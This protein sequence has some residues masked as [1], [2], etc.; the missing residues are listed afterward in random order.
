M[1]AP[2]PIP[3]KPF[4]RPRPYTSF[5]SGA[6]SPTPINPT[7]NPTIPHPTPQSNATFPDRDEDGLAR[8]LAL[9]QSDARNEQKMRDRLLTQ[10]EDDLAR[11]LRESL[12]YT[13]T[14]GSSLAAV[15]TS[16]ARSAPRSAV[17]SSFLLNEDELS[18]LVEPANDDMIAQDEALALR[19]A[20]EEAGTIITP[21][22]SLPLAVHPTSTLPECTPEPTDH[23]ASTSNSPNIPS[24]APVPQLPTYTDAARPQGS[25]K[26]RLSIDDSKATRSSS[27]SPL[28][29][30]S[31][32]PSHPHTGDNEPSHRLSRISSGASLSGSQG[33]IPETNSISNPG[34]SVVNVNQ[35]VDQR[36]LLGVSVGFS[37]PPISTDLIMMLEVMPNIISL[38]YGK[39]PPLH[40]QGPS[41][42]HLLMLMA[43]LSGTRME[44]ATLGAVPVKKKEKKLRTVI[45]FVKPLR[46]SSEWRTILYFTLDYPS[47][48][49]GDTRQDVN[50]L[51]Y[52]YS[53]S[54]I[55]TLL[56]DAADTSISKTYTIPA[57]NSVPYPTLPITF[58]N[59]AMYLHAALEDSRRY[60]N[61]SSRG[62]RKL[63]KMVQTCYPVREEDG[64]PGSPERSSV[65]DLFKRVIGRSNNKSTRTG[66][67]EDTY[68]LV[69][70]FVPNE[71]G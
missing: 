50:A 54:T 65:G 8:A 25:S 1:T 9:S 69:T 39:C 20:L 14:S 4:S 30:Q 31:A 22:P 53:L 44:V 12:M 24:S 13:R 2:P 15:Q 29:P 16:F 47:P 21:L 40:L 17:N 66:G 52:S 28:L 64:L 62:N 38:P 10:E 68:E 37:A 36:L 70:P 60:L 26:V 6:V 59:L 61:D 43:R 67:N 27:G 42:R 71:W 56:R 34:S 63:A 45:Q 51:P 41:W 5:S 57:S 48:R 46:T 7:I 35:F 55:P 11:A 18:I 3:P 23:I 19:L 33:S 49:P 58:P 32:G